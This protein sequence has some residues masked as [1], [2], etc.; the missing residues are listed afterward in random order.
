MYSANPGTKRMEDRAS[1]QPSTTAQ[2]GYLYQWLKTGGVYHTK[3]QRKAPWEQ[4]P[5][6]SEPLSE[7]YDDVRKARDG[8]AGPTRHMRGVR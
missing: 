5:E 1:A 2:V 7:Q 6:E 4:K 8:A 3:E